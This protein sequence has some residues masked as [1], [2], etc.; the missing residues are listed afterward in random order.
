MRKTPYFIAMLWSFVFFTSSVQAQMFYS[1]GS[2]FDTERSGS[3]NNLAKESTG[4]KKELA[5]FE[6]MIAQEIRER[7]GADG[8][9]ILGEPEETL[10]YGVA[11]KSPMKRTLTISG[12]AHT[13]NC[14]TLNEMGLSEVQKRL[15]DVKNYDS[16]LRK[17]GACIIAPRLVLR[18]RKGFDFV[19]VVISGDSCPSIS[20]LY[21]GDTK[22]FSAKPM[23]DWLNTFIEAVSKDLESVDEKKVEEMSAAMFKKVDKSAPKVEEKAPEAPVAPPVWGRRATPRPQEEA[24][25]QEEL[26]PPPPPSGGSSKK[27]SSSMMLPPPPPPPSGGF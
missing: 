1:S 14:G 12:Y 11:R 3:Q 17:S 26:A 20:F 6:K 23:G 27:S 13:G 5:A 10:C 15:F 2:S 9:Y 22:E 25:P 24:M 8:S 21:A 16:P 19:D 7:V 18:F 4:Q